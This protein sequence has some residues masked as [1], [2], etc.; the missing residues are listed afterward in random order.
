MIKV[1]IP[2]KKFV[3]YIVRQGEC[4]S[5]NEAIRLKNFAWLT[6]TMIPLGITFAVLDL[7]MGQYAIALVVIVFELFIIGCLLH[8]TVSHKPNIAYHASNGLFFLM[9]LSISFLEEKYQGKVLWV[10]TY[11]LF[12]I[13][14]FGGKRGTLWSSLLFVFLLAG[15]DITHGLKTIYSDNFWVRF[16][17]TYFLVV[18]ITAWLEND[19]RRYTAALE[20]ERESL[21]NE[22]TQRAQLEEQLTVLAQTDGLTGLYNRN[23]Y[24]V[25]TTQEITRSMRYDF[26]LT[27]A[28]IDVDDFKFVNDT[29]GHPTGDHVLQYLA[30][31]F[32]K[33]LRKSDII[34]RVG[35]EEFSMVL[36]HASL[37]EAK[38]IIERIHQELSQHFFTSRGEKFT[39]TISTGLCSID[40]EHKDIDQ[41]YSSADK[42]LY[43]A[44]RN[45]KNRVEDCLS[46][47]TGEH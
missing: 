47:I 32:K 14:V 10:Y 12:C 42:A 2:V 29:Y 46:T 24:W 39:V 18:W 38:I 15:L 26:P 34:G 37:A 25:L 40:S 5:V 23:H 16:S 4:N 33:Q 20:K 41:L 44:K 7:F 35:G 19:R 3:D 11:P 27:L 36:P 1:L 28:I 22:I 21:K 9:L 31:L 17:F 43:R 30:T 8:I 45:G 6:L 13:F